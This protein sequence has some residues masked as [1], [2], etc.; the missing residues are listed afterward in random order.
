M[1][2]EQDLGE[3]TRAILKSR[4]KA[5]SQVKADAVAEGEALDVVGFMLGSECYG[6]ETRYVRDVFP[7]AELVRLPGIPPFVLGIV[8]VR[9]RILSVVDLG[10]L[11]DLPSRGIGEYDRVIALRDGEM[12]FGLLGTAILGLRRILRGSLQPFLPTLTGIREKYLIGVS[13]ERMAVLD[14]ARILSDPNMVVHDKA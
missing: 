8:N 5:L 14:A 7:L 4:A 1:S 10:I 12:E 3:K 9:G 13:P 11:F 2:A 6:V